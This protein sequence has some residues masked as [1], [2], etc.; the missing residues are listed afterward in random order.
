MMTLDDVLAVIPSYL[1]DVKEAPKLIRDSFHKLVRAF[2]A[3]DEEGQ[4]WISTPTLEEHLLNIDLA[5]E[6]GEVFSR[7]EVDLLVRAATTADERD[8]IYYHRF[9]LLL[10]EDGRSM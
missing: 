9:S 4:G 3:L 5:S 2:A 7:E 1:T 10:A 8:R 6:T